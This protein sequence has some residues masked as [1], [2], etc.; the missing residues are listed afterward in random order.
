[1]EATK[2]TIRQYTNRLYEGDCLTCMKELPRESIDI[3]LCDL[4]YGATQNNRD[5]LIPLD[6]LWD[7][8][9]ILL[10]AFIEQEKSNDR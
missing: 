9:G 6:L 7:E 4:P 8:Y 10:Y 2:E 3:I 5:C 1:M